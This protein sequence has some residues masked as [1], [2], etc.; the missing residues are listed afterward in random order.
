MVASEERPVGDGFGGS[1]WSEILRKS[2]AKFPK[3]PNFQ[4]LEVVSRN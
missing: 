3:T 4:Y 2:K 1:Y